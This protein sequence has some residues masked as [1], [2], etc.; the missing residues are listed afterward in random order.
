M[1]SA[2]PSNVR[3]RPIRKIIPAIGGFDITPVVVILLLVFI[4]NLI[5][6]DI[7]SNVM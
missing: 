4:R 3:H 1:I 7:A 2:L 6:V 5:V